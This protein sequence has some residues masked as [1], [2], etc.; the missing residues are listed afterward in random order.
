M[1]NHGR[2]GR[3]GFLNTRSG[4]VLTPFF[5]PVGTR[6]AVKGVNTQ[7]VAATGAPVLLANTYHLHLQPGEK[8]IKKSGG[9]HAFSRWEGP[10]LTD[11]GGFQVYSLA[12]IRKITEEGVLFKDPVSGDEVYLTPEKSMK[13]QFDLGSDIILAFDDLTGLGAADRPRTAEAVARTHRWLIRCIAEFK[14]LTKDMEEQNTSVIQGDGRP[15]TGEQRSKAYM[16][17]AE[18]AAKTVTK[19]GTPSTSG[20]GGSAAKQDSAVNNLRRPLLFGIVQGGLDHKLRQQSLNFVQSTSVDGI[21]IGG[22]AVGETRRQMYEMLDFLAPLYDPAKAHYLMGVGEPADLEYAIN[23]GIDMTDCVLP[24]RNAR[25]GSVWIGKNKKINLKN[26]GF[27]ADTKPIDRG[28]DCQTCQ[29]GY[30]RAY[31]RHLF[32]VNDPLAGN[33]SSIHNLRFLARLCEKYR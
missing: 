32:K 18:R 33:L 26:A 5:M 3:S 10:I 14:R 6:G 16:K 2:Y 13:I 20:V 1:K 17:Y 15:G 28:C 23:A 19:P 31:L 29:T 11:S 24:T 25:H 12:K 8:L 21:A 9:L 30:S 22:L 7:Q 4:R 27:A